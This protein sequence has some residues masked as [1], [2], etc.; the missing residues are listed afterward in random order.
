MKPHE[1]DIMR[2]VEDRYWWYQA[3]RQ[4]VVDSIEPDSPQFSLLDAGCGTGGMLAAVRKKF[5]QAKLTG[6]DESEH[7]LELVAGRRIDAIEKLFA[8]ADWTGGRKLSAEKIMIARAERDP[9]Q[10]SRAWVGARRGNLV[11]ERGNTGGN[12]PPSRGKPL[13]PSSR[14]IRVRAGLRTRC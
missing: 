1:H 3:L 6:I 11:D 4:H 7:A 13:N 8:V 12:L 10:R 9:L 2:A 14:V 5:L